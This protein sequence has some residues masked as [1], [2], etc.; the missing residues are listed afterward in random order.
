MRN[1]FALGL[2]TA[3]A[4][5][6]S[7][8]IGQMFVFPGSVEEILSSE[9]FFGNCMVRIVPYS[10][11]ANCKDSWVSFDCSGD[12]NSKENSRRMFEV[13]QMAMA[14]GKPVDVFVEDTER[15]NGWCTAK[16]IDIRNN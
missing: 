1:K 10:A 8:A 5:I 6:P 3:A 16:R 14:L 13:A 12:F 9:E 15:H 7:L 11:P 4:L 2:I